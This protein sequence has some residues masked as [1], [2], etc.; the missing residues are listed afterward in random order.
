MEKYLYFLLASYF[1]AFLFELNANIFFDGKLFESQTWPIFFL[2]W[3]GLIYSASFF[4]FRRKPIWVPVLAW[5]FLGPMAEALVFHRLNWAV[6]PIIYG[7]MFFVPFWVYH[8]HIESGLLRLP[9]F[10]RSN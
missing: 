3:Y 6:D 4:A 7:L 8:K 5:I 1:V 9:F 2:A 10:N